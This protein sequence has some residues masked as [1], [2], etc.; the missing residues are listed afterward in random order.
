MGLNSLPSE[1]KVIIFRHLHDDH[2]N[3]DDLTQVVRCCRNFY[4]LAIP[5]LYSSFN[6]ETK[7]RSFALLQTLLNAPGLGRHFQRL[8]GLR[9][10][11]DQSPEFLDVFSRPRFH[12]DTKTEGLEEAL[13]NGC[14]DNN[15]RRR[16]SQTFSLDRCYEDGKWF[17][18]PGNWD[19]ITALLI[20]LLPNV[21]EFQLHFD[22]AKTT[23]HQLEFIPYV[24]AQALRLQNSNLQSTYCLRHLRDIWLSVDKSS[25]SKSLDEILPFL[26]LRTIRHVS[27]YNSNT[28]EG[29]D[30][31]MKVPIPHVTHLSF[32]PTSDID[33]RC[34]GNFLKAF[35]GLMSFSYVHWSRFDNFHSHPWIPSKIREGLLYSK[36]SL[37]ELTLVNEMEDG[38]F[39]SNYSPRG[40]YVP[41]RWLEHELE[42]RVHPIGSLL[43][44]RQLRRL[45]IS[46][47]ALTGRVG[48]DKT[49]YDISHGTV[50]PRD[51]L[52]HEQNLR[53]VDSLPDALEELSLRT[54]FGDIYLVME[55]LFERRRNGGL[56]RLQKVALYFQKD[57]SEERILN[58]E[59]GIQCEMEGMYLG[60]RVT[61]L[62]VKLFA[63]IDD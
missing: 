50:R 25:D 47:I 52:T 44:F 32:L 23:D 49:G 29:S 57:F 24:F 55:V 15:M 39:T 28:D 56:Q 48:T 22:T 20:L 35:T 34:L 11:F 40:R 21:L 13:E 46:V 36:D 63:Q 51:V 41:R 18:V 42:P 16:W 2:R 58:D 5:I 17:D 61:R 60:I 53:L 54:C 12:F 19:S 27:L 6:S 7:A 1:L 9:E 8:I 33:S 38:Y 30:D 26:Q 45:D 37:R 4:N 3:N 10:E 62:R 43:D 31:D 14:H 59:S